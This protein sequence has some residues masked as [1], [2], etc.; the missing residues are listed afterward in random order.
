MP[1]PNW[2]VPIQV[3]S[4]RP[5]FQKHYYFYFFYF[6][7]IQVQDDVKDEEKSPDHVNVRRKERWI[8]FQN[9]KEQNKKRREGGIEKPSL[10]YNTQESGQ[11][12][13]V[14]VTGMVVEHQTNIH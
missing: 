7:Q 12:T 11:L 6:Q 14:V 1:K 2:V 5:F 10:F 3:V 9:P 4:L 13:S 8:T